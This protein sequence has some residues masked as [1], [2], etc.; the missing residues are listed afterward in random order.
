MI[1]SGEG[2]Y[3]VWINKYDVGDDVVYFL[4]GGEKSHIGGIV[5]CEPG[6]KNNTIRFD[7]HYDYIVLEII[8]EKLLK[9]YDKK[10][11]VMGGIHIDNAEKY[12]INIIIENCRSL[13]ECI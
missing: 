3:K 6:K 7:N 5:I 9:K 12:E 10:I 11:I 4:G 8:A 13:A 2:K 1:T